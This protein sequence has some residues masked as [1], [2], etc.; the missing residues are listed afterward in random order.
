MIT[1][2]CRVVVYGLEKKPGLN[3]AEGIVQA[4]I[5]EKG[6]WQVNVAVGTAK[7]KKYSLKPSSLALLASSADVALDLIFPL[8]PAVRYWFDRGSAQN[9]FGEP[10]TQFGQDAAKWLSQAVQHAHRSPKI[11]E[12]ARMLMEIPTF[13]CNLSYLSCWKEILVPELRATLSDLAVKAK[14]VNSDLR[15]DE[16]LTGGAI[17]AVAPYNPACIP[18]AAHGGRIC[19][20]QDV[21]M[22]KVAAAV[23]SD[24]PRDWK[25]QPEHVYAHVLFLIATVID[26]QFGEALAD[27]LS[28]T[29]GVQLHGSTVL[30]FVQMI[31]KMTSEDLLDNQRPRPAMNLDVVRRLATTESPEAALNL[32]QVVANHFGGLSHFTCLPEW[33]H[34]DPGRADAHFHILPVVINV[35]FAPE[36]LTVGTLLE[37]PAVRKAWA[38]I[39]ATRPSNVISGQQWRAIHDAAIVALEQPSVQ[40]ECISMHCE[41]KVMPTA[42]SNVQH[43]MKEVRKVVHAKND[44]ELYAAVAKP[45]KE[46]ETGQESLWEAASRGLVDTV[47]RLLVEPQGNIL[48]MLNQ[49]NVTD[50]STAL[51]RAADRGYLPIVLA[52]LECRADPHIA[53]FPEGVPS[54]PI[55]STPLSIAVQNG[56]YDVS[57][58]LLEHGSNPNQPITLGGVTAVTIASQFDHANI[59]QLLIECGSNP[60]QANGLNGTTSLIMASMAGHTRTVEVLLR[61][62]ADPTHLANDGGSSILVAAGNGH[63]D[64]VKLLLAYHA[65]PNMANA[66]M[67]MP[68][69]GAAQNGHTA[70]L[71]VL[72]DGGFNPNPIRRSDGVTPIHLAAQSG[73]AD[74]IKFLLQNKVD[75]NLVSNDA[76]FTPLSLA[77]IN[78]H[79]DIVSLLLG[80]KAN[81]NK[82]V[83]ADGGETLLYAAAAKDRIDVASLLLEH[84]ADPNMVGTSAHKEYP[85]H[86][87]VRTGNADLV[88]LLI[89]H[90]A[91]YNTMS[92]DGATPLLLAVQCGHTAIVDLLKACGSDPH[93]GKLATDAKARLLPPPVAVQLWGPGYY[94]FDDD[95]KTRESEAMEATFWLIDAIK[96]AHLSRAIKLAG[97]KLLACGNFTRNLSVLN[98][99]DKLKEELRKTMHELGREAKSINS[100][101]HLATELCTEKVLSI[102]FFNPQFP[103]GT[104]RNEIRQDKVMPSLDGPEVRDILWTLTCSGKINFVRQMQFRQELI[105]IHMMMLIAAALDSKFGIALNDLV[106]DLTGILIQKAPIKSYGRMAG[107]LISPEDHRY[108]KE[109]PRPAMNIDIVRR[110]ATCTSVAEA[111]AFID[112]ISKR[113]GGVS[114]LKCLPELAHTNPKEAEERFH[115]LPV[116][117]TVVFAPDGCTLGQIIAD[118]S[119]RAEWASMRGKRPGT[120]CSEQWQIDHDT[121]VA[122]LEH[123]NPNETVKMHCEIQIVTT[124]MAHVRHAMHEV[125]KVYRADTARQLHTD[126]A[127]PII[128][129]CD[130]KSLTL[131]AQEGQITTLQRLLQEERVDVNQRSPIVQSGQPTALLIASLA[132]HLPIVFELLEHNADPNMATVAGAYKKGITP[133]F[134]AAQNGYPEIVSALLMGRADPN[135]ETTDGHYTTC[136]FIASLHGYVDVVMLLLAGNADPMKTRVCVSNSSP[137]REDVCVTPLEAALLRDHREVAK[138]LRDSMYA[139]NG[140][141]GS[142]C[143]HITHGSSGAKETNGMQNMSD[144]ESSTSDAELQHAI[145]M[146][147]GLQSDPAVET[148]P[149][150]RAENDAGLAVAQTMY[151]VRQS[152]LIAVADN[153]TYKGGSAF[154]SDSLTRV[155]EAAVAINDDE[156]DDVA[157][158]I[159]LSMGT[160][161]VDPSHP[162][163]T[164]CEHPHPSQLEC[165]LLPPPPH[166]QC[167]LNGVIQP[168]LEN[169]DLAHRAVVWLIDVVTTAHTS[170]ATKAAGRD[171]LSTANFTVNLQALGCWDYFRAAMTR[172]LLTLG[173]EAKQIAIDNSLSTELSAAAIFK[174]LVNPQHIQ[175]E[176]DLRQD[177]LMPK[178]ASTIDYTNWKTQPE[179]IYA[180]ILLLLATAIHSMFGDE[181]DTAA[182][183]VAGI[184]TG[185]T[186]IKPYGRLIGKLVAVKE[187]RY[188][189]TLPRTAMNTD[190]V[191]CLV[192]ATNAASVRAFISA[193]SAHFGGISLLKCLPELTETDL[194]EAEA[195]HFMLPVVATVLFAPTGVTVGGLLSHAGVLKMWENVRGEAPGGVHGEQW[196]IYH[197]AALK[198]L[199]KTSQFEPVR[200]YCE[201]EM[202][203]NDMIPVRNAMDEA[204]LILRAES[205]VQLFAEFTQPKD[206]QQG[207]DIIFASMYGMVSTVQRL[208]AGGH[209]VN[210]R[211][212]GMG[213]DAGTPLWFASMGGYFAVALV[214]IDHQADPN[215]ASSVTGTTPLYAAAYGGH[216]DIVNVLLECKAD[217]NVTRKSDQCTP[218]YAAAMM[219][220]FDVVSALLANGAQPNSEAAGRHAIYAAADGNHIDIVEALV[221]AD[222]DLNA[223]LFIASEKGDIN[224]VTLLVLSK[225]DPN[226]GAGSSSYSTPLHG[227]AMN[228]HLNVITALL[229]ADADP[230]KQNEFGATAGAIAASRGHISILSALSMADLNIPL[231]PLVTLLKGSATLSNGLEQYAN[232]TNATL[233]EFVPGSQVTVFGLTSDG[234][235]AYNGRTGHVVVISGATKPGRIHVLFE[236]DE[237]AKS[238]KVEN[239]RTAAPPTVAVAGSSHVP[240]AI[241]DGVFVVLTRLLSVEMNGQSGIVQGESVN[242]AGRWVVSLDSGR[243]VKVMPQNIEIVKDQSRAAELRLLPSPGC[244][245]FVWFFVSR[246]VSDDNMNTPVDDRK[247][248][249]ATIDWLVETVSCAH[250][251][252]DVKNAGR[253]LMATMAFT[254][255]LDTRPEY[256]SRGKYLGTVWDENLKPK[257][258]RRLA[259]LGK[260]ARRANDLVDLKGTLGSAALRGIFTYHPDFSAT[261]PRSK[262]RQDLLIPGISK[263]FKWGD[264]RARPEYIFMH[265]LILLAVA[266]D[267]LYEALLMDLQ[268]HCTGI[269][270]QKAPVKTYSRM[271]GKLFSADDHRYED[272]PRPA[273]NIDLVRR[274]IIA[275]TGEDARRFIGGYSECFGGLSYVKCL[276][277]LAGTDGG[278]ARYNMLPVMLTAV[279][280]PGL[281]LAALTKLPSTE[282]AWSQLRNSPSG[283]VPLQQWQR[284]HDAAVAVFAKCGE[285]LVSMHCEAQVLLANTVDVRHEMHEVYKLVRADSSTQLYE[286]VARHA[287]GTFF[288]H[289][290]SKMNTSG[291]KSIVSTSGS[292]DTNALQLASRWGLI[293]TVEDLLSEGKIDINE[294]KS[295]NSALQEAISRKQLPVV[296][297]LL[298]N[299]ANPFVE[300]RDDSGSQPAWRMAMDLGDLDVLRA[301]LDANVDPNS[302]AINAS[303]NSKDLHQSPALFL[304]AE[305]GQVDIVKALIAAGANPNCAGSG[306][307][308]SPLFLATQVE[309]LD[310]MQALL[311]AKADP[312]VGEAVKRQ[313]PLGKAVIWKRDKALKLLISANSDLNLQNVDQQTPLFLAC[314]HG[315]PSGLKILLDA[316]A[317]PEISSMNYTPF[318]ISVQQGGIEGECATILKRAGVRL[319]SP[320]LNPQ[321]MNAL[322]ALHAKFN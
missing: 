35:V 134:A 170:A 283:I 184:N 102:V 19:A 132:G 229:E 147:L 2:G 135:K 41:V 224:V 287:T 162:T 23:S 322:N 262:I 270:V 65:D 141:T 261:T 91:S 46:S 315:N 188:E 254:T 310:I 228:G 314:H 203:V 236:G 4:E 264:W 10:Q 242:K 133:L 201:V 180:H 38:M 221:S 51:Q 258:K 82:M 163:N 301:L 11:K 212:A 192:S 311:E 108:I 50:G 53:K 79:A 233:E 318:M 98:C 61:H 74:T 13:T 124:A 320:G 257:L 250:L 302:F 244:P 293:Q 29:E 117:I 255:S 226:V 171:L 89:N 222:A 90:R 245:D 189:K 32:I 107:K 153:I 218:L 194:G 213:P 16:K 235:V 190:V 84:K 278:D 312:N 1:V 9:R 166:V 105:Y 151:M 279:F 304:A 266:L 66:Q 265:V 299:N 217:P 120:V 234:G 148:S 268:S 67:L 64:V 290:D 195:Q 241:Q 123:F 99:W 136:L 200:I 130:Q 63:A 276:P 220:Y 101:S 57:R 193:T 187:Y 8:P 272:K 185:K 95:G 177:A 128:E 17:I 305:C 161:A 39:R 303:V 55:Y 214:L 155:S 291:V 109:R 52:L 113:F 70:V 56:H 167:W 129:N 110:L 115:M 207:A 72:I 196:R 158:T 176:C 160:S 202:L 73:H 137:D 76:E 83:T 247:P 181:V 249:L 49:Q 156:D 216:F 97:R 263:M 300:L 60:N 251:S 146:S 25:S 106:G 94:A 253:K 159:Q 122:M 317:D 173:E 210:R 150:D 71:Q 116:M 68:A 85:M 172:L 42:M 169:K 21:L 14:Q 59:V 154:P 239:L 168:S 215:I 271:L 118:K 280:S 145:A 45:E 164:P 206:E 165:R 157:R 248:L 319:R 243:A 295:R 100:A 6:R 274:M 121:A 30:S 174:D 269:R 186:L 321:Q 26:E 175:L 103:G 285:T 93:I 78:G 204:K 219:G 149:D 75:V 37:S 308:P 111:Q 209:S 316:G 112:R 18:M 211:Q 256:D 144:S 199:R 143:D 288:G 182:S 86:A 191:R 240:L 284:D 281:T 259:I 183:D 12:A 292:H 142:Q 246:N 15:L 198:V 36:G 307:G 22:P 5:R 48:P 282:L 294:H 296:L 54:M 77:S 27:S 58:M 260:A 252:K 88:S 138:V 81:P 298:E 87:A 80:S 273:M 140:A 152:N 297:T 178:L 227:A 232:G 267:P 3:G 125:Y 40:A 205:A 238:L 179:Q 127:E 44:K 28:G 43:A 231:L 139:Y 104:G 119:V 126:C 306:R 62:S 34:T 277:D 313:T 230:G 275:E 223:P 47:K 31:H 289:P 7:A 24:Y 92:A 237:K 69:H 131:A 114:H 286:D 197:D 225:A 208:A 20:R 33:A 309:D 96:N